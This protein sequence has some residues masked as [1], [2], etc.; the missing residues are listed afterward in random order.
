MNQNQVSSQIR[1]SSL[2]TQRQQILT[3]PMHTHD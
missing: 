2:K 3:Q 1:R